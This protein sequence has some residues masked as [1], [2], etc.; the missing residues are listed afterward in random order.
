[1]KFVLTQLRR[2]RIYVTVIIVVLSVLY[3]S[4]FGPPWNAPT[5]AM[6]EVAEGQGI[7]EVGQALREAKL[8]KSPFMFETVLWLHGRDQVIVAGDY[9]FNEPVGLLGV[10]RSLTTGDYGLEPVR[11]TIPEGVTIKE[12]SLLFGRLLPDFDAELFIKLAE[13]KEGYLFPDTYFILP[14]TSESKIVRRLHDNFWAQL[15][16]VEAVIGASGRTLEDI[17]IM[18]SL[19]EEEARTTE[20]RKMIAGILWK[21][22]DDGMLLQVD[23]VF[24]YLIGKNSFTLTLADLDLDSPYNTYK[25]KGLPAGPITNPGLDSILAAAQPKENDYWFYLSDYSGNM[26][27]A[28]NFEIHKINKARYLN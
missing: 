16:E 17:I 3:F 5:G 2:K 26:H 23:A 14:G 25:Y 6:F 27:Y 8:I 24:P 19:L 15:E 12:M 4:W 10:V 1:M 20:S 11:V 7:A 13:G 22:L 28:E 18:A 9:F 21:R